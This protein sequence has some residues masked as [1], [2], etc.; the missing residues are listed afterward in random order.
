MGKR[1][2]EE[3]ITYALRRAEGGAPVA[4]V[5]SQLGVSEASLYLWKEK[6]GNLG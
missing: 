3:P 1:F 5:C 4:D 6:Y 2:A